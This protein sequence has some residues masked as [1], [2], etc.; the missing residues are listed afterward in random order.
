MTLALL[1]PARSPRVLHLWLTDAASSAFGEVLDIT[2]LSSSAN[3]ARED[4]ESGF[5]VDT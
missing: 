3:L 1:L 2:P 5:S 4:A